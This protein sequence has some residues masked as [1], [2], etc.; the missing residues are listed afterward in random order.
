MF[1]LLIGVHVEKPYDSG[2]TTLGIC[3]NKLIIPETYSI[4]FEQSD[5]A[6]FLEIKLDFTSRLP[7]RITHSWGR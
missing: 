6:L 4:H 3:A 5:N 7:P 2:F 1:I